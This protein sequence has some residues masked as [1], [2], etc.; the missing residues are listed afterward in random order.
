[1]PAYKYHIIRLNPNFQ[2][3]F[4][5]LYR[6]DIIIAVYQLFVA[7]FAFFTFTESYNYN[8]GDSDPI[9]ILFGLFAFLDFCGWILVMI[10]HLKWAK[11]LMLAEKRR[12][13]LSLLLP[14]TN[15]LLQ[16]QP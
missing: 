10:L 8:T 9:W 15:P 5:K 16:Q 11:E 6:R 13:A 12:A 3:K 14:M 1:M 2:G 4:T 7:L